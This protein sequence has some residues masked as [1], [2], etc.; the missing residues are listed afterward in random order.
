MK[1]FKKTILFTLKKYLLL[2]LTIIVS[3]VCL[4]L[5]GCFF[6]QEL[7]DENIQESISV[8]ESEG[9]YP[10]IGDKEDSSMLDNFTDCL[11]LME[12][13]TMRTEELDSIFSNPLYYDKNPVVEFSSFVEKRETTSP[14]GYYVRYWMGFRTPLRFLLTFM[15]YFQIRSLLSWMILG[16]LIASSF[17]IAHYTDV[18]T[19]ILF[20]ISII[21]VKPQVVCNSLQF[22][23]CFVLSLLSIFLVPVVIR[24]KREI[25]FFF[26][27]GMI[28]M[29]F[30]FYTSP[31]VVLGYPLIFMILLNTD[32]RPMIKLSLLS[33]F[34]W[35]MGYGM[36]WLAKLLCA[37]LFTSVNGFVNGFNS[38]AMRIGITKRSDLMEYYGIDNAFRAIGKVML[39]NMISQILACFLI[40]CMF[41]VLVICIMQNRI[42][43]EQCMKY[44][45]LL[46]P[47]VGMFIW[48]SVASQPTSIHAYFQYRNVSIAIFGGT[49]Y[50]SLSF[51]PLKKRI[52]L[53]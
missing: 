7:I 26:I 50:Y 2:Y 25:D 41:V 39:P 11:I 9:Q 5:M 38:F 49:M 18:R 37:T 16:L 15:N 14:S 4:L 21:F 23:C 17:Y 20:A 33:I 40:V 44:I 47:I 12:S 45:T 3:S 42:K 13:A 10:R 22:S 34:S 43:Y 51:Y 8:F 24:K 36:M 28:T 30:D 35:G 27:L 31:L 48:Y 1:E 6:S 32:E 52:S 19:G 46:F 29:Y 53:L